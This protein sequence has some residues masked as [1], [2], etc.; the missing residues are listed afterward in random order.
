MKA[1]GDLVIGT[2]GDRKSKSLP[3]MNADM[4]G[5]GKI[6]EKPTTAARRH[7]ERSRDHRIPRSTSALITKTMRILRATL[8]E[9]FDE[10]AYDR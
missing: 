1:S 10:S 5:S 6:G 4:R 9:I 8:R 7:R 2:S 3:L